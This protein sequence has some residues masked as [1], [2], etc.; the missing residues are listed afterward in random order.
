MNA[1]HIL[2]ALL[3]AAMLLPSTV[4][5]DFTE[6]NYTYTV[7]SGKA[8]ITGYSGPGGAVSIP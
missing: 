2:S 6:G 4:R 1:K 5:A 8:T 3:L 7:T